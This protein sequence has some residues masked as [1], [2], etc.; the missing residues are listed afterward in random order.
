MRIRRESDER[1]EI[2]LAPLIDMVFLLL[3]FFLVAT[4]F[5]DPERDQAVKLPEV[6]EGTA[7]KKTPDEIIVNVRQ[8]GV[9]VVSGRILTTDELQQKLIEGV[10]ENPKL[11]VKVRGDAL[12]YHKHTV[13]V[14]E[15]C[16]KAGIK[17]VSIV[18]RESR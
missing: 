1:F 4:R 12:V 2:A 11:V 9:L 3:I 10:K 18:T 16:Q 15:L 5:S 8:G 7:M 14:L 6:S 17:T 13:A